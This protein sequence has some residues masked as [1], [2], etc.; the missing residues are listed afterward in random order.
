MA[1]TLEVTSIS[2]TSADCPGIENET[3]T[4]GIFREGFNFT[5]SLGIM[6]IPSITR[7]VNDKIIEKED[8]FIAIVL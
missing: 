4:S 2:T 7:Q 3:F 5:G 1:S 8:I 6:N